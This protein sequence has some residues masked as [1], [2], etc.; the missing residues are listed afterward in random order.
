MGIFLFL[1]RT[2]D[3]EILSLT[4]AARVRLNIIQESREGQGAVQA[5]AKGPG[6]GGESLQQ[7][8]AEAGAGR[9]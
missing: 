6:N 3:W 5:Q 7:G 8:K 4:L 1:D 9:G 2:L